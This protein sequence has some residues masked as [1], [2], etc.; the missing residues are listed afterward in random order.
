MQKS[1]IRKYL[2]WL[3]VFAFVCSSVFV[4]TGSAEAA[5]VN[6][7]NVYSHRKNIK[8]VTVRIGGKKVTKKTVTLRKGKKTTLKVAVSPR[9]A[10]KRVTYTSS[11][12]SVAT[13]SKKGKVTAKKA[14]MA[15]IKITVS[16][17]GY[18][19]KAAWVKIRVVN[20]E[21]TTPD[22]PD[23]TNI[24]V[25]N[26]LALDTPAPNTPEP[27][28]PTQVPNTPEPNVPTPDA[29][30]S[31]TGNEK[32]LVVYFSR[33]G[34]TKAVAEEIQSLT[35]SDLVELKT[36]V[37][38]PS[39]YN[40]CLAQAQEERANNARPEL[41]TVVS[42][43]S[44]YDTVYVGYPIWCY[45]APMAIFTF[46][47]SYDFTGKTVIP[48]CTSGSSSIN[49]S[50]TDIRSICS[51]VNVLDGFRAGGSET[52]EAWLTRTR[53]IG[54]QSATT[55]GNALIAY[56]SLSE[57][58]SS[59]KEEQSSG[60]DAVTSASVVTDGEDA[61]GNTEYIAKLIRDKTG[62]T[63][64][65]I[66]TKETYST[67]FDNVVDQNHSEMNTSYLP[68]LKDNSLDISQYD[69]VFIGY[70]VWSSTIPR[71]IHSFLNQYDLSGKTV[72]PFCTHN[73][74][75]SGNS[76]RTIA[77][78]CP[79]STNL[80]GLAVAATDVKEAESS[81][82]S[83]LDELNLSFRNERDI[84]V[85][86]GDFVLDGILYDTEMAKEISANFPLT[87]SLGGYGGREYYGSLPWTPQTTAVGQY[88]FEDG[89]ITYCAQNNTIAIFYAQTSRPDL[90]MEVVPV[91]KVIS[92]L[93]VFDTLPSRAEF[94][95]A[96]K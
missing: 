30:P 59:S 84:T 74:Y 20:A 78:L 90:T 5:N 91:G 49:Q 7:R 94:T 52:V 60:L 93:S 2:A 10:K 72:I 16:G 92:D 55:T 64:Y 25:P 13:V 8:S 83:W 9:K 85:K 69:I 96:I 38:Y 34:N 39:S 65:Q 62:G 56:F 28:T 54:N 1:R 3:L 47:E 61:Y 86:V 21:N 75:G 95:F 40:D 89:E 68:E 18:K 33:T 45:T 81:V 57:N 67:D 87:V 17:K 46:L 19:K 4:T 77:G 58:T 50:V 23:N 37:P 70:P 88:S 14:G 15:K 24:P 31:V 32:S 6:K 27:S 42:N 35:G 22:T 76:Y 80:D 41:S 48:F 63:L 44:E 79:N 82:E 36:V 26:S 66:Q 11:K 12:K 29:Q 43:M 51:G 73:G 53:Q 71:A